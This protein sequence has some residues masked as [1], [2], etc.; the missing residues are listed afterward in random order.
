MNT[1]LF[2]GRFQPFH[3]GH[4]DALEQIAT[5]ADVIKIVIGSSNKSR[6]S[7]NP[8]TFTE[9]K[10]YLLKCLTALKLRQKKVAIRVYAMPDVPDDT[11]WCKQLRKVAG[12]FDAVITANDWVISIMRQNRIATSKQE[13]RVPI[14]AT[15]IRTMIRNKDKKYKSFLTTPLPKKLENIILLT[16]QDYLSS[17]ADRRRR[18]ESTAKS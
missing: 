13:F 3:K 4:L 17:E 11:D 18:I 1:I 9:R 8:L 16:A 12:S 6:T 14:A 10:K 2:I 7:D 5:Q 15:S